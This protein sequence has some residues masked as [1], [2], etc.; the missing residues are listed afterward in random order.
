MSEIALSHCNSLGFY[1]KNSAIRNLCY[2]TPSRHHNSL[3]TITIMFHD[4]E[5][6][7]KIIKYY[8]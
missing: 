4:I 8:F 5:I 6:G 7:Q 2:T 3:P 1:I